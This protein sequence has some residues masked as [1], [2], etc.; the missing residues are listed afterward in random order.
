MTNKDILKNRILKY[1]DLEK[2]AGFTF[3]GFSTA[4]LLVVF[5]TM[6]ALPYPLW[7]GIASPLIIMAL[8][9]LIAGS[10][11]VVIN[12]KKE[13][14]WENT[15]NSDRTNFLAS[16]FPRIKKIDD[17][18]KISANVLMV[19]ILLSALFI[20]LGFITNLGDFAVGTGLG[21]LVPSAVI[22]LLDQ[23]RA[24]NVGTHLNFLNSRSK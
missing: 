9:H 22:Y 12:S 21:L 8:L 13:K 1:Y 2:K 14:E 4:C 20:I 24:F 19:L 15:P 7:R 16:E 6:N 10:S 5:L 11:I 23:Y 3:I 18:F 17:K